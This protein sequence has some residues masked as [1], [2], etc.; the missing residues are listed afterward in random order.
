MRELLDSVETLTGIANE[1]GARSLADLMFLQQAILS[2]GFIDHY[3]DESKVL[4]IAQGLPSGE[5]WVKFI[6]VEYMA[7][8][9]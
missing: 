8:A 9:S 3:A 7:A 5:Q 1:H 6:K 4:E 2:G